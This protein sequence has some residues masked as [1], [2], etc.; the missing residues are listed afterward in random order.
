MALKWAIVYGTLPPGTTLNP[1]SGTIENGERKTVFNYS[2]YTTGDWVSDLY[3]EHFE[4]RNLT[5]EGKDIYAEARMWCEERF[6]LGANITFDDPI[7]TDRSWAYD[8]IGLFIKFR[9]PNHAF[10]FRMRWC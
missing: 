3:I 5:P 6:G 7:E 9:E 1:S 10:E 2:N 8:L 4:L